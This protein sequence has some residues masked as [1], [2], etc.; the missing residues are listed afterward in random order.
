MGIFS[1]KNTPK[2]RGFRYKPIYWD[3]EKEDREAAG[4]TVEETS[5]H[6]HRG[7][8]RREADRKGLPRR[9]KNQQMLMWK[10]LAALFALIVITIYLIVNGGS[11]FSLYFG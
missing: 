2:P 9:S 5:H 8:F 3:K 6:I 11:Y 4:E 1:F 10:L 7:S